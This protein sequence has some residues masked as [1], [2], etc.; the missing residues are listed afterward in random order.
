MMHLSPT[1][2]NKD[3]VVYK[4]LSLNKL[5][6]TKAKTNIKH[7]PEELII[8]IFSFLSPQEVIHAQS[9]C[10]NWEK[11]GNKTELWD[12]LYCRDFKSKMG[13]KKTKQDYIGRYRL[14]KYQIFVKTK[15]I[16][17]SYSFLPISFLPLVNKRENASR[18]K[19][20]D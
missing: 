16:D 1:Q 4:F 14:K 15:K 11:I 5:F 7:L 18:F 10:Q 20:T 6:T 19:L 12:R 9:V 8:R 13:E 17:F 3:M 2:S